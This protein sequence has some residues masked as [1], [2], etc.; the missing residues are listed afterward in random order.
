[1]DTAVHSQP[2]RFCRFL[3]Q[4][5]D[6]VSDRRGLIRQ[7]AARLKVLKADPL[8]EILLP[9]LFEMGD[10]YF[11]DLDDFMTWKSTGSAARSRCTLT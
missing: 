7:V 10:G 6:A 4:P 9:A 2:Q 3:S 11:F 8:Q 5:A 1:S